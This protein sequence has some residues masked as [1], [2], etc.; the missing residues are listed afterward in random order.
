MVIFQ[1]ANC[2]I[3]QRVPIPG[4]N[5]PQSLWQLPLWQSKSEA[6]PSGNQN[7]HGFFSVGKSS[8]WTQ[9]RFHC[10][11]WLPQGNV[12]VDKKKT[13]WLTQLRKVWNL[14]DTKCP[15]CCVCKV[16][17]DQLLNTL[18]GA[19]LHQKGLQSKFLV[20][21]HHIGVSCNGGS[22]KSSSLAG[23]S[24]KSTIQPLGLPHGHGNPNISRAPQPSDMYGRTLGVFPSLAWT[25]G[26]PAVKWL[27]YITPVVC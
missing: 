7:W 1:F 20:W 13:G 18:L 21:A 17:T 2:W 27:F 19:S 25:G 14:T 11:V 8:K 5:G 3:Y 4:K 22:P 12:E 26:D 16:P 10:H 15:R 6:L 24:M 23:C 9:D